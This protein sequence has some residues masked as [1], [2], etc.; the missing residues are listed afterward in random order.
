[1]LLPM[2]KSTI[3]LRYDEGAGSAAPLNLDRIDVN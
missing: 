1:V 2:G 3:E